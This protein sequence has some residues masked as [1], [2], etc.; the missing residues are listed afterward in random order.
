MSVRLLGNCWLCLSVIL[1]VL[2]DVV[3]IRCRRRFE[4][5]RLRFEICPGGIGALLA[6][7]ITR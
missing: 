1:A 6:C 3:K 4:V 2:V 5:V 7:T